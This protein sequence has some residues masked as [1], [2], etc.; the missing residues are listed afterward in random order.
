VALE[1]GEKEI[2]SVSVHADWVLG[3]VWFPTEKA[4][5]SRG[6][7]LLEFLIFYFMLL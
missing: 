4:K 6:E 2:L 3:F 5:A 1:K 7:M